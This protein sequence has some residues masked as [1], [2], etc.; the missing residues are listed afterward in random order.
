MRGKKGMTANMKMTLIAAAG[1]LSASLIAPASAATI[2]SLPNGTAVNIPALN[3]LNEKGPTTFGPGITFTSTAP[4]AYGWS[5]LYGFGGNGSWAGT[6]MIGLNDA[7]GF[8]TLTFTSAISGFLADVNWTS[9][10]SNNA[11]MQAFDAKGAMIDEL[12]LANGGNLVAPGFYGFS[13]TGNIISSI[14]FSNKYIGIRSI[15]IAAAIPEPATWAMMLLGFGMIAGA[16]RY[17]RRSAK[18]SFT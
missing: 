13:Q 4:A 7:E 10:F 17:R 8:F 15:S 2:T 11:T 5:N 3:K 6:P 16:A 18:V 14:R 12:V 9:N 1:A